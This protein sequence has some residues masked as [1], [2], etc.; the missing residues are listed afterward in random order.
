MQDGVSTIVRIIYILQKA[1]AH[2]IKVYDRIR[3]LFSRKN[4]LY[5][6]KHKRTENKS[7]RKLKF[8][9]KK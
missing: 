1:K 3:I 5:M 7:T 4:R 2:K 9:N 8:E 6:Q